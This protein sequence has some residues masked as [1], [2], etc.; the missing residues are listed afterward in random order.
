MKPKQNWFGSDTL[1]GLQRFFNVFPTII[2][3]RYMFCHYFFQSHVTLDVINYHHKT[4]IKEKTMTWFSNACFNSNKTNN[5]KLI[6]F[7]TKSRY[8]CDTEVWDC[9]ITKL[10][11]FFFENKL[12]QF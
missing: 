9:Y 12:D 5:N 2:F 3:L 11:L 7:Q 1:I 4:Y 6:G 10:G 8:F